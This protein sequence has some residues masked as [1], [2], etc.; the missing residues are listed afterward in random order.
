MSLA[1]FPTQQPVV[2]LLQ[3]SL[4]RGR[5]GHAYLFT[6]SDL[7]ELEAMAC[8]L[9]R[10]LNCQ[11]PPRRA[12]SGLALDSCDA[13]SSCRR[14]DDF[15]HPDVNW[16]RP[17]SKSRIIGID[18]IRDLMQVV[19]LKPAEAPMKVGIVVAADRLNAA[20]ANAF[21][22]T[23]E[24]PPPSSILILLTTDPQRLLETILSRCLRLNFSGERKFS[25]EEVAWLTD[26][27]ATAARNQKSLLG[28]YQLLGVLLNKLAAKKKE[29]ETILTGRS[30]LE[31]YDDADP[32]LREKWE[33]ELTAAIEADYRR[34]RA[35]LLAGLEW[36]LRDVWMLTLSLGPE[37][38]SFPQLSA[39]AGEVARRLTPGEAME[40]VEALERLLRLLNTN[41]QEALA[42]EIGLLKLKL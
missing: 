28:R 10:T 13:C 17:E 31:R 15:N 37:M 30:P 32:K 39:A 33:E 21:L 38:L 42:I 4:E 22:K 23:L 6:G 16:V 24:E 27:S 7:A 1:D 3:R 26:F 11:D 5:L 9:A 41:V 40:N 2:Q 18:Q 19:N 8:A 14:I 35:D 36:W 34:Q 20:S 12:S 25:E 29:I